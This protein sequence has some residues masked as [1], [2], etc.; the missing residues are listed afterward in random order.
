RRAEPAAGPLLLVGSAA[1]GSTVHFMGAQISDIVNGPG[2][3][4]H[5]WLAYAGFTLMTGALLHFALVFPRPQPLLRRHPWVVPAIYAFLYGS[6]LVWIAA[7]R[8]ATTGALAWIARWDTLGPIL[9]V[10]IFGGVLVAIV[11]GY[12]AASDPVSRRQIRWVAFSLAVASAVAMVLAFLPTVVRGTT[13]ISWNLPIGLIVPIAIA[14]AIFRE[15][16]FDIDVIISRTLIW[17]TLS[18][19]VVGAYGLVVGLVGEILDVRENLGLS[20]V[21]TG[22]IALLFQPLRQQVQRVVNRFVYGDRDD[23]YAVVSRLGQRLEATL[24]PESVLPTIAETVAQALK[25]PYVAITL[26]RGEAST[27][28]AAYGAPSG[29]LLTLPLIYQSEPVGELALA[30]RG[31]GDAFSTAD[32][33]LLEDLARQIG[34]A[35][36][37]VRLTDDLQQSRQRIVTAREEERRRLR[38]DLHD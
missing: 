9:T 37:A 20:L 35:A 36:H 30:T 3:W 26:R 10:V 17:G 1:L 7:S 2:F 23:P 22:L 19:F 13:L 25:L 38:R 5:Q 16:L 34:I 24:A 21:A 14:F 32:R 4:L 18:L 29:D 33:R 15:R 12:R 11:T 8:A 27:A 28:S 31:P 6:T